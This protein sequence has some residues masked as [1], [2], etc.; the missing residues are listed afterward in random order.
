MK[1]E[2]ERK[3]AIAAMENCLS[4]VGLGGKAV[5]LKKDPKLSGSNSD[6]PCKL[7]FNGAKCRKMFKKSSWSSLS[8]CWK[9]VCEAERNIT[10]AGQ[11][12]ANRQECWIAFE[13]LQVYFTAMA[14]TPQ[15]IRAY[16]GKIERWG[17]AYV[18]AFGEGAVTHYVVWSCT[19]NLCSLHVCKNLDPL[20]LS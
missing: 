5:V 13:H 18:K 6:L 15:E 14:L 8:T 9:D 2:D 20:E 16:K 10:D 7:S 11:T 19:L 17:K 3:E 1:D 4:M 12:K